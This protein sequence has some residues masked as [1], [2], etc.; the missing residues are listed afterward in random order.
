MSGILKQ[1]GKKKDRKKIVWNEDNLN[2]NEAIKESLTHNFRCEEPDTPFNYEFAKAAAMELE[3]EEGGKTSGAH[4]DF[5]AALSARFA[6]PSFAQ[7]EQIDEE[8][9]EKQ[10][11]EHDR[12]FKEKRK[13]HYNE[14]NVLK[15]HDK[16]LKHVQLEESDSEG[17]EADPVDADEE[18]RRSDFAAKR[19]AFLRERYAWKHQE[20]KRAKGENVAESSSEDNSEED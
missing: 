3:N 20:N 11:K 4:P 6:E 1:P 19:K 5:S 7:E 15:S 13:L 14:G 10:R 16:S 12:A 8:E 9:L 17:H 2:E 18:A